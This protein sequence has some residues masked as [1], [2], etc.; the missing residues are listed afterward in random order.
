MDDNTFVCPCA[1]QGVLSRGFAP[2][3]LLFDK[4]PK[5]EHGVKQSDYMDL[6]IGALG[7][8]IMILENPP[9]GQGNVVKFF[10]R[11]ASFRQVGHIFVI[12]PDRFRADQLSWNGRDELNPYFHCVAFMPLP[13][14]AFEN[15]SG[16][17]PQIQTS[18]QIWVRKETPRAGYTGVKVGKLRVSA[19]DADWWVKREKPETASRRS[20]ELVTEYKFYRNGKSTGIPVKFPPGID[21][22]EGKKILLAAIEK[23]WAEYPQHSKLSLHP[24]NLKL[25]LDE[26]LAARV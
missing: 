15:A 14:R 22:A 21:R 3:A 8:K 9:F 19:A 2:K 6:D 12:S 10:N 17:I 25:H 16:S 24:G 18:F 5:P 4:H 11:M 26:L 1:G 23:M 7:D 20:V 13:Y